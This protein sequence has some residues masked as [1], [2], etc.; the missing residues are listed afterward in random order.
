MTTLTLE[1]DNNIINLEKINE[2]IKH[3]ICKNCNRSDI[4]EARV[5]MFPLV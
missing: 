2:N 4:T 1:N 5:C 3:S